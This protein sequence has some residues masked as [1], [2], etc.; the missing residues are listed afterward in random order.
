MIPTL[1]VLA[2]CAG[3]VGGGDGAAPDLGVLD[4]GTDRLTLDSPGLEGGS[5]EGGPAPDG[6]TPS[7]GCYAVGAWKASAAFADGSRVSHPLP[8]FASNGYYYVHTMKSGGDDRKL[9]SAEALPGGGL[10]GWQQASADHGGGPHGF[11]AIDVA[12]TPYHFRNGHI[13]RYVL[14]AGVM[15]GDVVLIEDSTSTAFGGNKY[16]WDSAVFVELPS[17]ERHVFHLGGFS[18]AGYTYRKDIYR[19]AVPVASSFT[20]VPGSGHPA[21][22]PGRA[23]FFAPSGAGHGY[24]FTGEGQGSSL[25]RARIDPG[26][27][28][29]PFVKLA[30][31]PQGSD[32]GRGELFVYGRTLF[33]IRG[34]SVFR[35]SVDVQGALGTW[36]QAPALPEAQIDVSWGDGHLEGQ[37]HGII[38][39]FVYV[40]GPKKVYHAPLVADPSC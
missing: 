10:S 32:N 6:P 38:G 11:T 4:R 25:W 39:S 35:A 18:F 16:V 26:G 21:S 22:R 36:K 33:V 27:A 31:L 1:L 34:A 28:L 17:G 37:A 15:Q 19:S 5:P 30:D 9:L 24:L 40:T 20:K 7:T 23:A 13:A 2:A 3:E 14:K 8:S 29:G 12:G